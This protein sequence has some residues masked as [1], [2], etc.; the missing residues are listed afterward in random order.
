[1]GNR[2]CIVLISFPKSADAVH[3]PFTCPKACTAFRV[4]L[5]PDEAAW[6]YKVESFC[7]K[8][9]TETKINI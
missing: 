5:S 7:L 3:A 4:A 2:C 1:M 6:I 9:S 8:A